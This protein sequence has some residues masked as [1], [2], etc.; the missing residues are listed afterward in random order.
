M[1]LLYKAFVDSSYAVIN[2]N[3]IADF[4][5]GKNEKKRMK[6]QIKNDVC[7]DKN[8]FVFSSDNKECFYYNNNFMEV[9]SMDWF[10]GVGGF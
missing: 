2:I 4:G 10:W 8:W 1:K 9:V 6:L 7:D 5:K 3:N